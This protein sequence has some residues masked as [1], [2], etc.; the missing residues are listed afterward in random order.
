VKP[1]QLLV[2]PQVWAVIDYDTIASP[3][4]HGEVAWTAARSGTGHGLLLWFD[5]ALASGVGFSTAPSA[6]ETVYASAF[7]PWPEPLLLVAGD[8]LGATIRADLVAD[9]YVWSWET[10]TFDAGRRGQPA[11]HFQQSTFCARPL[12]P[13]SLRKRAGSHVPQLNPEGEIDLWILSEMAES[14]GASLEEIAR[15]LC[16]RYPDRFAGWPEALARVSQ[17]SLKYSR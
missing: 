9:R 15:R 14:G 8:A 2:A 11:R 5:A 6:P 17:L 10:R 12:T 1:D 7:F 4:V 3:Q 16:R 13:A